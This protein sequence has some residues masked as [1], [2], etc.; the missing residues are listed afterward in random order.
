MQCTAKKC[1]DPDSEQIRIAVSPV[2]S[3]VTRSCWREEWCELARKI[4]SISIPFTES[5]ISHTR[6][7]KKG[8]STSLSTLQSTIGLAEY[9]TVLTDDLCGGFCCPITKDS[10]RISLAVSC[11]TTL[12]G[13]PEISFETSKRSYRSQE[14][15]IFVKILWT[16]QI[17]LQSTSCL[18]IHFC[19]RI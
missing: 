3:S 16:Q 8:H 11:V 7:Q 19:K 1:V 4:R 18:R 14:M 6:V 13:D 9:N 2:L 17:T 15:V 12:K 5:E 10:R